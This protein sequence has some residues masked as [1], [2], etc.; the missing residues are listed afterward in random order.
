M[1][2]TSNGPSGTPAPTGCVYLGAPVF[3]K[4][5]IWTQQ[6]RCTITDRRVSARCVGAAA[7]RGV[8]AIR[9]TA[10]CGKLGFAGYAAAFH[11][12]VSRA[13][14]LETCGFKQRFWSLLGLRPKVT[15]ARGAEYSPCWG[16]GGNMS[17]PSGT[18]A[19]T[20]DQTKVRRYPVVRRC[21]PSRTPAPTGC[22]NG[23][24]AGQTEGQIPAPT[25]C[26]YLGAPENADE[27][28]GEKK[29]DQ[30]SIERGT[31]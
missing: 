4:P 29:R 28:R 26:V 23:A 27:V 1:K 5:P 11:D 21:G 9:C 18:P 13:G 3:G 14:S 2:G 20:E 12:T 7:I 25:G 24:T 22:E 15:C 17:G 10:I 30:P 19:P 31:R 6:S 8:H 16:H